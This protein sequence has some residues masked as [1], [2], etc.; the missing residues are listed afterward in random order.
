MTTYEWQVSQLKPFNANLFSFFFFL[1][2]LIIHHLALCYV[3]CIKSDYEYRGD[4]TLQKWEQELE[5]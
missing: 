2:K 4:L 5:E 1:F 3:Q